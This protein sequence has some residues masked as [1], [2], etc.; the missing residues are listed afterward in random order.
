MAKSEDKPLISFIVFAYNQ[1]RFIEEAVAGAFGQTYS[2]LEI[3]LSDDCSTDRT[4]EVMAQL[5]GA[6]RGS[7]K[8]KL[9][10]SSRNMGIGAHVSAALREAQGELVV[11]AAGDDVSWKERSE[12]VFSAWRDAGCSAGAVTSSVRVVD[13]EGCFVGY[14]SCRRRSGPICGTFGLVGPSYTLTRECFTRF[15]SLEGIVGE[16]QVF[17]L[18][19]L[20]LGGIV[21]VDKPLVDYRIHGKS[22]SLNFDTHESYVE[23]VKEVFR[24]AKW[25]AAGA[26]MR[27]KDALRLSEQ[28]YDTLV[29][30]QWVLHLRQEHLKSLSWLSKL[31]VQVDTLSKPLW[32]HALSIFAPVLSGARARGAGWLLK[33]VLWRFLRPKKLKPANCFFVGEPTDSNY[34]LLL[35]LDEVWRRIHEDGEIT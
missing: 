9:R 18:R 1:E 7:H 19:A 35:K 20:F 22:A 34:P 27:L 2:P 25:K 13:A 21:T 28:Q 29:I 8:I 11:M 17:G 12:T 23:M 24:V 31:N 6:Y 33:R 10:R 32:L 5:A 16:D 15:D 14:T 26:E 3:I 30:A 4:Y